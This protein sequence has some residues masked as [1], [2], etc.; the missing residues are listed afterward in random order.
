M[1]QNITE[2]PINMYNFIFI[3]MYQL[4]INFKNEIHFYLNTQKIPCQESFTSY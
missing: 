4:K 3:Y 1:Y 2:Y